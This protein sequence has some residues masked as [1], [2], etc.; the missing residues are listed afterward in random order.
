MSRGCPRWP[1]GL[2]CFFVFLWGVRAGPGES[3]VVK[4]A[5]GRPCLLIEKPERIR[6]MGEPFRVQRW[7]PDRLKLVS[8]ASRSGVFLK[9]LGVHLVIRDLRGNILHIVQKGGRGYLVQTPVGQNLFFVHCLTRPIRIFKQGDGEKF[10]VLSKQGKKVIRKT[11]GP[12]LFTVTGKVRALAASFL[13]IP[14][15]SWLERAGCF[16]LFNGVPEVNSV[17]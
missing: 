2:A 4:D 9:R 16:L 10:V 15:L 6:V 3:V 5:R 12:L 1:L 8:L 13:C 7:G 17:S 11:G 14:V